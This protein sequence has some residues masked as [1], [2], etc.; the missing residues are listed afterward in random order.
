MTSILNSNNNNTL[1][2]FLISFRYFIPFGTVFLFLLLLFCDYFIDEMTN[3][4]VVFFIA[5]VQTG[6]NRSHCYYWESSCQF[7]KVLYSLVCFYKVHQSTCC[8]LS[9]RNQFI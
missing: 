3:G 5:S 4:I 1:R 2:R 7:S 6:A 8:V 9:G